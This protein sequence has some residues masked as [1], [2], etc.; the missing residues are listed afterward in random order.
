MACSPDKLRG[1][2]GLSVPVKG[3]HD[4]G[5]E[6]EGIDHAVA[7][8]W[9]CGGKGG[10]GVAFWFDLVERREVCGRLSEEGEEGRGC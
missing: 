2:D 5:R 9:V 6:Q 8:A 4:G 7:V 3:L 10:S 1:E